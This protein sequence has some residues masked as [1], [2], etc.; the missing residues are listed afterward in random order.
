MK[1]LSLMGICIL[2]GLALCILLLLLASFGISAGI[3]PETASKSATLAS[4]LIGALLSSVI[5]VRRTG[6]KFLLN[7][8]LSGV[9][10][11]LILYLLGA[12]LF[13]RF[14]PQGGAGSIFLC[15]LIGGVLGGFLGANIKKR[16]R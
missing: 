8:L 5:Y 9:L 2:T 4:C 15:S 12:L 11:F 7:G 14:I 16:R 13:L 1:K 10:Y 3:L 6:S